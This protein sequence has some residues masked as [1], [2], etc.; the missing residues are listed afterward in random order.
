MNNPRL[1]MRR[2]DWILIV[3]GIVLVL[4][5]CLI[6]AVFIVPLLW[7][8]GIL[9]GA[10]KPTPEGT[11]E[12]STTCE[13]RWQSIRSKGFMTVGTSADYPPFEYYNN[14]YQIDGFD[15]QLMYR[16]GQMLG[17]QVTFKDFAFEGLGSAVSIGQI[18]AAISA[19]SITPER[20]GVVD[21]SDVYYYGMDAVLAGQNSSIQ[22]IANIN[23]MAGYRTGVQAGTVYANALQ[24]QLVATGVMPAANLMQYP[25]ID[26]AIADLQAGRLD[27]VWLDQQPAAQFV[28]SGGVKAVAQGLNPQSYAI[29]ICKGSEELRNQ[30]NGAIQQLSANGTIGE[31]SR[32][33]LNLDNPVTIPTPTPTSPA[34]PT[35]TPAP[36]PPCVDAMSF[37]A[38]LNY[39]D[40]NMKNPARM[41]PGQPFTKGW[42]IRNSGTC[43]WT[44]TYYF[45]YAGGNTAAAQMGGKDTYIQG[46]VPPGAVY[47]MYVNLVA[48]I[49][50]GTYQGFWQ[51]FSS[52]R[53]PFGQKVWVGIEVVPVATITPRPS[54]TPSPNVS[55][56]ASPTTVNSGGAVTF[57]WSVSGAQQVYFYPQG[58]PYQNYPVPGTSSQVVYPT[59]T[60]TYELRVIFLNGT[61]EVRQITIQVNQPPPPVPVIDQFSVSPAEV[62]LGGCVAISWQVSGGANNV[63]IYRNQDLILDGAQLAGSAQDCLGSA[64]QIVYRLVASNSAGVSVQQQVSVNVI[65]PP[66][67]LPLVG[68]GWLLQSYLAGNGAMTATIPGTSTTLTLSQDGSAQGSGGCNEFTGSY[69]TSGSQLTMSGISAT[70]TACPDPPGLMD[71]ENAYLN[72]LAASNTYTITGNQLSVFDS[73]GRMILQFIPLA[74]PR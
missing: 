57:N 8:G 16:I 59:Q 29:A 14:N 53:Y 52:I 56:S 5:A 73:S 33:Y 71:Q 65:A 54:D 3:V 4:A 50:P 58:Q 31:L 21:F 18:D 25:R 67:E 46:I 72:L 62:Q 22:S 1:N 37:V 47:D 11:Q 27:I 36:P 42:R 35:A 44:S 24:T 7:P 66:D 74:Q 69:Q 19:I 49:V 30:I 20:Q 45:G 60:T 39:P 23:Q 70:K 12:L 32:L 17:V 55:F 9:G 26:G 41:S 40:N 13:Q 34:Q 28:Q 6:V 15:P 68:T 64:G 2:N 10:A 63:E 48:P 43:P 51:M 61:T 38:D